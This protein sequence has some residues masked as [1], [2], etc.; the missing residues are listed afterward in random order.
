[1]LYPKFPNYYEM[2]RVLKYCMDPNN[3]MHPSIIFAGQGG[4]DPKTIQIK[5]EVDLQ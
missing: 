1:L 3:I 5:K 4:I 2:M